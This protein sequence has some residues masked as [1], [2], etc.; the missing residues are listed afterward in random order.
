MN[1]VKRELKSIH[2][3]QRAFYGKAVIIESVDGDGITHT[4]K[5]Q[6][7]NTIVCTVTAGDVLSVDIPDM[8]SKTTRRHI[9]EFIIQSFD[10]RAWDVI[11]KGYNNGVRRWLYPF[12]D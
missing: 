7:Y 5:L 6:S 4:T 2:T 12:T 10:V 8:Y 1:E 9:R 3:A 11:S